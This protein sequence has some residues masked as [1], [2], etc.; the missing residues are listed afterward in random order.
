MRTYELLLIVR[1]TLDEKG[2]AEAAQ[3]ITEQ[4]KALNGEVTAADIWGRRKL[5]YPINKQTEGVYILL[6]AAIAPAALK[7]LD[8]NLK[9][10]EDLLRFMLVKDTGVDTVAA[11]AE[12]SEE[13]V[14]EA[15]E[16]PAAT[17]AAKDAE[18]TGEAM[19]A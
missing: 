2:A 4:I 15:P 6:K 8:F 13:A 12:T 11:P 10:N 7:E 9:L 19:A 14:A 1:P 3:K 16:E 18:S 5:A 17:P